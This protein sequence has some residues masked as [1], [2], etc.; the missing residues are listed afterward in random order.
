M[1]ARDRQRAEA[2]RSGPAALAT[3]TI[4]RERRSSRCPARSLAALS[5]LLVA[6]VGLVLG[7][8]ASSGRLKPPAATIS[9]VPI[10]TTVRDP[11]GRLRT[12]QTWRPI[13]LL[14]DTVIGI[15]PGTGD[16]ARRFLGRLRNGYTVDTL[17]ILLFGDNRPGWRATR[18]QK[19][20]S[21]I[22]EMASP[23]PVKIM[24]GL[25]AIPVAL[26]HG[27]YPDLALA[28]DVPEKIRNMPTWGRE[29]EVMSAMLNKVDSLHAHGQLVAAA[30]NTGDLVEDGRIPAHWERFLE[31]NQPLTSRVPYFAVAGNHE[32]TDT[33]DGV[34]NWRTAT[35]LPV[36]S[37]R[38]YY[39]FDSADGWVRFIALDT[40]P[41]VD[42]A[43][44]WTREVQ[45]KY[46]QEEFDWLVKRVK[47]HNGPVVVMMHHPP[48]SSG[49]HR[50]EWQRDPVL[51]ERRERMVQALHEAG[52]SVI[53]AGHEHGYQRMLMTW[54]DAVLVFVASGGAGAPLND[55]QSTATTAPIF[56]Q[57]KVA[58]GTVKPENTFSLKAFH[59]V[60]AR[61]WFGG[62][63]LY[64]YS[65]DQ[66]GTS[67]LV[68]KVQVDLK[69][70]GV[71]KIDQH[72]LVI[73][74]AKGPSEPLTAES[75]KVKTGGVKTDSTAASRRILSK[76]APG[77]K[78]PRA[79]RQ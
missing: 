24:R 35:G 19:E 30:I 78:T 2:G 63:E 44:H 8:A 7:C 41:I 62:G 1:T 11:H 21:T 48:F 12:V 61:L 72:K 73:A 45:V 50:D 68:D 9:P 51:V 56:A 60:L 33:E 26:V 59:F 52:I 46:S 75:N 16:S 57:Y 77:K 37:D 3:S 20:W 53:I 29:K 54:P 18:L 71:P 17:N 25:V 22:H 13:M 64:A 36:G 69:R 10:D 74:P 76:P 67:Q 32:R 42:P 70:Y 40:N 65:V 39:C 23:N 66:N 55:I 47:E 49:Y 4:G 79:T 27:L 14:S 34:A 28:R 5:A 38:L 58:G 6:G 15:V 31:L 43:G